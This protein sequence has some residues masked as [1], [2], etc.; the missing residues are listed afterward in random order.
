MNLLKLSFSYIKQRKLG[1]FLNVVLLALG[2]ATIIVLL[3]FSRQMED[4]LARNAQG[5]DLVV[6]AKGSPLQLILSSNYHA[7][8][9]T[10]NISV[11]DAQ[12]IQQNRAVKSSI[13]L[14]LGDSYGGYRI[15][16]TTHDYVTHYN[17]SLRE[18]SLW[19]KSMEVVLGAEAALGTG[20]SIG[21]EAI[22]IHGFSGDS[23][24]GEA[25]F[26][27]AGILEPTGTVIDRLILTGVPT[28]WAIHGQHEGEADPATLEYTSLLIQYSSPMAAALFPRFVNS[29]TNL[30]AAAPAFETARLLELLGVGVRAIRA[31]AFILIL[32]AALGVFIALYNAMKE[33]QYDLAVMRSMGATRARLLWHV[34]IEGLLLAAMGTLLGLFLG[35]FGASLLGNWSGD[36]RGFGFDG[37]QWVSG[38]GWVVAGALV[39]GL[40]SGLIPAIQAYRTDI[41]QILARR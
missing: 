14:A 15:I 22:S 2:I 5:I 28:I 12:M 13:P 16:G 40:V 21:D 34:L 24:H 1:T 30:Q 11:A 9:P 6:G 36:T 35:H 25:P 27:V 19:G 32:A 23:E 3:I 8:A 39:L 38:E 26:Q 10:G 31:F 7:D 41:A 33:R 20:L 37:W 17:A 4:N 18:G 29:Q